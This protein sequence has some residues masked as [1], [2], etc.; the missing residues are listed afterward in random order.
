MIKLAF[1]FL[2]IAL[3]AGLLGLTG[4]AGVAVDIAMFLFI[5]ALVI[6]AA[7]LILGLTVFKKVTS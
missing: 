5:A 2:I 6:F 4:I 1:V 7:L 3:I